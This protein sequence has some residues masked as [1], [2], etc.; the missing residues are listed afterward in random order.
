MSTSALRK[1]TVKP[2]SELHY[3]KE[4]VAE[5]DFRG[6]CYR[7]EERTI[8]PPLKIPSGPAG[9]DYIKKSDVYIVVEGKTERPLG[10][11]GVM[12]AATSHIPRTDYFLERAE[13]E[14]AAC[15]K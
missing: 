12:Y 11:S 5:Q 6:K 13:A 3:R 9:V 15:Q 7:V 10:K 8:V 1:R 4:H 2:P 14:K